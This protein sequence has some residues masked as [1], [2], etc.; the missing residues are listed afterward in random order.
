MQQYTFDL[1][2]AWQTAALHDF[3][4]DGGIDLPLNGNAPDMQVY[5]GVSKRF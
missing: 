3:Q 2:A 5:V 4:L 1:D